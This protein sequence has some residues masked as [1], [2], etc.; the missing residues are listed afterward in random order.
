[1]LVRK[2]ECHDLLWH[3]LNII[4][5]KTRHKRKTNKKLS[6]VPSIA[7]NQ[8]VIVFSVRPATS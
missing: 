6:D 4:V 7:A 1:M 8:T 5:C 3:A 2:V